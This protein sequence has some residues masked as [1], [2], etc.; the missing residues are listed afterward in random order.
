V[1]FAGAAA[2]MAIE[3]SSLDIAKE[4]PFNI[5]V[6]IGS[7]IGS[8]Y[9]IEKQHNVFLAR[10][11]AK[12]SPF[13]IPMLIISMASGQIAISFGIKGPNFG[14]V[15]ACASGTH[16]IG[17]AFRIIQRGD[18]QMMLAGGSE[19]CITT[20]GLGAFC[21]MKVLSDRNDQPEKASRPFDRDRDG[22]IM[23]EGAGVVV[24]ES[25]EHA[26]Q[27]NAPIYGELA[28]YGMSCDA[29]HMTA[30]E[31]TGE[32]GVRAISEALRD[33]KLAPRD[34]SY[35]NAH[36]TSTLLNDRVETL[37]IKKVFGEFSRKI[38][39]S[40]IKSMTG[41]LL[42]AA[43]AVEF[44]TCCLSIRDNIISPTVNYENQDPDC[45][46]DYVPNRAR[47]AEVKTAMSNSFG[48][49]GHNAVLV[50]KEFKE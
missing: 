38:P 2:G 23:A 19:A 6:L 36:G 10:G 1:Q 3:D 7:G 11:P 50:V 26:K 21:A 42:G 25:L 45:D 12:I 30:P 34:I 27:R 43:G 17:S 24:L 14:V 16:A 15:T 40:S 22:F 13:T 48:F 4:D 39:V 49:G 47:K 18:A 29:Y 44:I 33:A 32:G 8:L 9:T 41:H 31:P 35:I 5:G 20:I 28:G 46:L 37:A